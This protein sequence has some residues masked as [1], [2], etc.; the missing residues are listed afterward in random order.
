MAC[1]KCSPFGGLWM[2]TPQGLKRCDCATGEKLKAKPKQN[3]PTL[4]TEQAIV[5][6]EA[7]AAIPF[8]PSEAGA[9][10]G[11]ADELRSLC[12]GIP[13]ANWLITRMRRLYS[14]WPGPIE[15][16]RVYASKHIP[17]DGQHPVGISEHYPDGIPSERETTPPQIAAPDRKLLAAGDWEEPEITDP[18]V[19]RRVQQ[20]AA[21]MPKMPN[22][23]P[24]NT[25]LERTLREIETPPNLRAELP[26][27][28]PQII[29]QADV[30]AAVRDLH[31]KHAEVSE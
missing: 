23:K 2:E 29:T 16:R 8:F 18:A 6:T 30:D 5:L 19:E 12:A 27:P 25:R 21:A 26:A 15:M 14:R 17:W 22:G 13:E 10:A 3:A 4:T 1:E 31:A 11:I 9:R 28:T 20:L 24:L 7:L